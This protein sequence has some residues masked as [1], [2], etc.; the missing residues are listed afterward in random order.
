[1]FKDSNKVRIILQIKDDIEE[2][3]DITNEQDFY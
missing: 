3:L 1:M 2:H